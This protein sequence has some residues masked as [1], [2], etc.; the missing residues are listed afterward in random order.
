MTNQE[1]VEQL[2]KLIGQ[3]RGLHDEISMLARK[4]PSDGLNAFKLRLI[5][6]VVATGNAVLGSQYLPFENF[7]GFDADDVPSNSDVA[8]VLSQYIEEAERYRSD[9]VQQ[10]GGIWFYTIN[11]GLSEVRAGAPSKVGR[12]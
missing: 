8:L 3:L 2:E 9:N 4:S 12:K 7:T 1:E 10:Y 6:Q 11:G 5:N